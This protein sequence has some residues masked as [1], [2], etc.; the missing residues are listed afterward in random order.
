[1]RGRVT[2]APRQ[3]RMQAARASPTSRKRSSPE[4][5][6][7]WIT[8]STP[9]FSRRRSASERS[10]AVTTRT[11]MP[12]HSGSSAQLGDELEPVHLRHHQVEHDGVGARSASRVERRPP[13]LGLGDRPA[14][15]RE[16]LPHQAARRPRRP[17]PRARARR[18]PHSSPEDGGQPLRGRR[19]SRGTRR[20]PSA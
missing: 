7:F 20:R 19:A 9:P 16:R 12:R 3:R 17:R 1:M 18:A 5:P 2:P 11:G 10:S 13:V 4:R 15:A 14:L 6:L 8:R